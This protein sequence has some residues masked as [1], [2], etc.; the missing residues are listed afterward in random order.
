MI[1]YANFIKNDHSPFLYR[2]DVKTSV[3]HSA[4]LNSTLKGLIRNI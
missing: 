1:K 3:I 2:Y 4:Y